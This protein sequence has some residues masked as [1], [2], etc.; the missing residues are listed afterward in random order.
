MGR[1]EVSTQIVLLENDLWKQISSQMQEFPVW[2]VVLAKTGH[3]LSEAV[4]KGWWTYVDVQEELF[5]GKVHGFHKSQ[6]IS[7]MYHY[8]YSIFMKL[9]FSFNSF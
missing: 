1:K 7:T 8:Y 6:C 5:R 9:L 4:S 3:Q 2:D